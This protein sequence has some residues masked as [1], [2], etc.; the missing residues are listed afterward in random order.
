MHLS[1]RYKLTLTAS[2]IISAT[3]MAH[4]KDQKNDSEKTLNQLVISA[5]GHE[6]L[7]TDAPASISV[8]ESAD[9]ENKDY[10]DITDALQ[11]IPGV[12]ITGS[13]STKDISIRGMSAQYTL[14]LVDGKRQG[15]R[16]TRPNSDNSGIEQ[17]WLPPLSAIKRIEVIRGPM[18]S[19]YGSDALGGVINVITKKI[20]NKWGGELSSGYTAQEDSDAGD[21]HETNFMVNGPLIKDKLGLQIYG[22]TSDSDEDEFVDGN[23]QQSMKNITG[24]L[25][26][27]IDEHQDL[28]FAATAQKQSRASHA[29]KSLSDSSSDSTNDY[30]RDEYS[31]THNASYGTKHFETYLTYEDADNPGRDMQYKSTI[32]NNKSVFNFEQHTLTLGGQ[33]QKEEL[34]DNGNQ[35]DASLN[36]LTRWQ[37][38]LFAEDEYFVTNTVSVT[39]GLRYNKDENYG[40]HITPRL[41]ANWSM[42]P[43]WTL[44]GGVSAGYRSPDLRQST[45]GWGQ[46]T[47]GRNAKVASVILGN[48]DLDPEKSL[49]QEVGLYWQDNQ[50]AQAS[51]TAYATQFKDKI[52]EDITCT[53][54]CTYKGD[55]YNTI[56]T[57][58]NID[59]VDIYG[60][61]ATLTL[62]ITS[63]VSLLGNYTFTD[64][65]QKSGKQK[66]KPLNQLPKHMA[67]ATINWDTTE[68]LSTWARVNYR[69]E[70]TE[71]V[72]SHGRGGG[73]VPSYTMIDTGLSYQLTDNATV[74]AG[75]YNLTDR[76]V[77]SDTYG[78]T[79]DGRRYNA[80]L[81]VTF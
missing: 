30:S 25:A 45:D 47:G 36:E 14:I 50:G 4:A 59:K 7:V 32:L 66:G 37:A 68:K 62:P 81:R 63:T 18:S 16:E 35:I 8:I 23:A 65:E 29:G 28:T 17:G 13:G 64:S 33:Y 54:G 9:L 70:T 72:A 60:V 77:E 67:N 15:T 1:T 44:K 20:T 26:W 24:K 46:I 80:K 79:L 34:N 55:N 38:A 49:T 73:S 12:V 78:K 71:T 52:S 75:I 31:L 61:E 53:N 22:Q 19:L 39:T 3:Q 58:T 74:Y 51:V 56:S 10:R 2:L 76:Q 69:G 41:Y 11:D 6:Q 57:R 48:S 43:Q 40:S 42:T 27:Q 21:S 5:S